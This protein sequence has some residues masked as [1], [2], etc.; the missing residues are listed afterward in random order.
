MFNCCTEGP[1]VSRESSSTIC[2]FIACRNAA[3]FC[4][5]TALIAVLSLAAAQPT[6][7]QTTNPNPPQTP[8][9]SVAVDQTS[10]LGAA[11]SAQHGS[12]I[13]TY[14]TAGLATNATAATAQVFALNEQQTESDVAAAAFTAMSV[15]LG[16]MVA[17]GVAPIATGIPGSAAATAAAGVLAASSTGFCCFQSCP[18]TN[19]QT[20][21]DNVQ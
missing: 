4:A 7:A 17:Y 6:W 5:H 11:Q 13:S 9:P 8:P 19:P 16:V 15:G 1:V 20:E 2:A 10:T 3:D 12:A 21:S 14:N 18:R